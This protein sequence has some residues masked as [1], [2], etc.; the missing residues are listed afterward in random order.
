MVDAMQQLTLTLCDLCAYLYGNVCVAAS[1]FDFVD[2]KLG[3]LG[4]ASKA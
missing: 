4:K 1:F 3:N 2:W